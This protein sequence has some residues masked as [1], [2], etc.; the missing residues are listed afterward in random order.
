MKTTYRHAPSILFNLM[1][2]ALMS[3]SAQAHLMVAQHGTLNFVD[4]GAFMVLSLPMSAFEGIDGDGDGKVSMIEF[5]N[6]RA[7]IVEAVAQNVTLGDEQGNLSLQDIMLSPVVP[8][9]ASD[10]SI[11]QLTIMGRFALTGAKVALRF[12]VDLLGKQSAEQ[13]LKITA[14]RQSDK[15]ELVFELTPVKPA[16]TLFSDTK[17]AS[18][19]VAMLD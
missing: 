2:T 8:H 3:S 4:D 5:N 19:T 15:Q 12:Q 1:L 18:G 13:L 10:E 11:A 16:G 17:N 7:V 9:G 6:H 14:T